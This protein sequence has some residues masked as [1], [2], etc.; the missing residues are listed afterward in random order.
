MWKFFRTREEL[1]EER[2]VGAVERARLL[3]LEER[4][5]LARDL[6]DIVAH[7]MSLIVVQSESADLRLPHLD[8]QAR[9]EM[10]TISEAARAALTET[11]ALLSVLR[12]E[13]SHAQDGPPP[14][15]HLLDELIG[16]NRRAGMRLDVA[17][18]GSLDVLSPGRSL[19]GYRIVQEALSNAARHA[20]GTAVRFEAHGDVDG[21]HLLVLNGN[22]PSP[23]APEAPERTDDLR[24]RWLTVGPV[25]Q[26]GHGLTGMGE[27]AIAAGGRFQAGP[28]PDGFVAQ[29]ILPAQR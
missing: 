25:R 3:V 6:H 9:A 8:E 11:R 26:T 21:V 22:G 27:R 28:T 29:A 17:I 1:L 13:N 16:T 23:Q 15:L 4:A 14:G 10:R 7:H 2:R 18:T 12:Q 24:L 5:E 19:A 20:P